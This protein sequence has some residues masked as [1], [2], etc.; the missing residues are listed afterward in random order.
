[1]FH[2]NPRFVNHIFLNDAAVELMDDYVIFC[3][4][5][6]GL[7]NDFEGFRVVWCANDGKN[8]IIVNKQITR[9]F[10]SFCFICSLN[11]SQPLFFQVYLV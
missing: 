11:H 1:M 10:I 4:S 5:L 7:G 3:H 9:I 2:G 6:S 8:Y